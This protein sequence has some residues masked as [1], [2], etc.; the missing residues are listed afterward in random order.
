MPYDIASSSLSHHGSNTRPTVGAGEFYTSFDT[1][2]LAESLGAL[3][4]QV[5][6]AA[7]WAARHTRDWLRT[8]VLRDLNEELGTKKKRLRMRFRKG[9]NGRNTMSKNS[10][11]ATLWIGV[12]PIGVEALKHKLRQTKNGVRVGK[13]FFPGAFVADVYGEGQESAWKRLGRKRIPLMKMMVPIQ[14]E[15]E[16]I[17][18]HYIDEAAKRFEE[19]FE[20]DLKYLM[21]WLK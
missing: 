10:S 13:R 17:L 21:G 14:P 15:V 8:Q 9:G 18:P 20:H 19:R 5:R 3:P 2:E 4:Q 6:T 1:S 12:N 7:T 16:E 11:M